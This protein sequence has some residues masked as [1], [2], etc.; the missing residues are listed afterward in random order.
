[1]E[2]EPEI[3]KTEKK[4]A[5]RDITGKLL[6]K[7][8]GLGI[9]PVPISFNEENEAEKKKYEERLLSEIILVC[10]DYINMHLSKKYNI[11]VLEIDKDIIL[12]RFK[13]V[14]GLKN[15]EGES[16]AGLYTPGKQV[17]LE[18]EIF[19]NPYYIKQFIHI[20]VHELLHLCSVQI[21]QEVFGKDYLRRGGLMFAEFYKDKKVQYLVPTKY[22]FSELNEGVVEKVT[23]EEIDYTEI[24]EILIKKNPDIADRIKEQLAASFVPA[25]EYQSNI[26]VVEALCKAVAIYNRHEGNTA[27]DGE[28]KVLEVFKR[29]TLGK[30][31]GAGV[32]FGRMIETV[33]GRGGMRKLGTILSETHAEGSSSVKSN[34]K[35]RR[36]YVNLFHFIEKDKKE[37]LHKAERKN[38]TELRNI[39]LQIIECL[40]AEK[41]ENILSLLKRMRKVPLIWEDNK[42]IWELV[43]QAWKDFIVKP[44][45]T[46]DLFSAM[47]CKVVD[48]EMF[49]KVMLP[50]DLG[51]LRLERLNNPYL[52]NEF[53][54][55]DDS[56]GGASELENENY[57]AAR[58]L[59]RTTHFNDSRFLLEDVTDRVDAAKHRKY[60]KYLFV[61]KRNPRLKVSAYIIITFDENMKIP[62]QCSIR[63]RVEKSKND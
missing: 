13:L 24:E 63:L 16:A 29:A 55:F 20:V 45:Y 49:N 43:Y 42:K 3:N 9:E 11:P 15:P 57:E 27:L 62:K 34:G 28:E 48:P 18:K 50:D 33:Y 22:L 32:S 23:S 12:E 54:D 14:E 38:I 10:A 26:K 56:M 30:N 61:H 19:Q 17:D 44:D 8:D 21:T 1:M 59:F 2:H 7:D 4:S 52:L 60:R 35:Y 53:L 31:E 40:I 47:Q 6:P 51:N 46:H 36:N 37:I 25:P 41:D 58:E 39:N 5:L